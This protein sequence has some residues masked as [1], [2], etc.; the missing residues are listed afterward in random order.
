M[1]FAYSIVSEPLDSF[2]QWTSQ[3]K[4]ILFLWICIVAIHQ[5]TIAQSEIDSLK[6]ILKSNYADSSKVD[7]YLLLNTKMQDD[8]T[9][10]QQYLREAIALATKIKD[11]IRLIKCYRRLTN[12]YDQ[13]G[14]FRNA[15]I[16]L[17]KMREHLPYSKNEKPR[18]AYYMFLGIMDYREGAYDKALE[19][20]W[21]ALRLFENL[22]DSVTVASCYLNI[23][24]CYKELEDYT[25]T[26]KY[27]LQGLK[28]YESS[29]NEAL[30]AMAY[31][32]IGNVHK[33]RN[34]YDSALYYYNKSLAVNRRLNLKEDIHID[35]NNIGDIFL[36]YKDYTKAISYFKESFEVSKSI[37]FEWGIASSML[38]LGAAKMEQ[39]QFAE[40]LMILNEA[41]QKAKTKKY[42][43]LLRKA[44]ELISLTHERMGNFSK[45]LTYRKQFESL[46]DSLLNE[47]YLK[48]AKE[49]ELKYET[50]KKDNQIALLAK[51]N[52]L[53]EREAQRQATL[54]NAFIIGA[55]FMLFI[56]GLV[57]YIFKQRLKNQ[58]IIANKN[59][60]LKEIS[61]TKQATELEMK[62]LRAQINPH[63]LFNCMNSI[64]QMIV[65]GENDKASSYLTKFSKL[66]RLI[67]E[68]A[69]ATKVVL[70]DE[71]AL[72][73]AYIQMESLRFAGK[74]QYQIDVAPGIDRSATYIPPMVLQ[75]FVE[76]AIWH[77][78]MHK[79]KPEE[80]SIRLMISEKDDVLMCSIE[81]NGV[82]VE[83]SK[84]LQEKS[85]LKTKSM[86]MSITEERLKLL[87]GGRLNEF[88]KVMDRCD[89]LNRVLGTQVQVSIPL[90]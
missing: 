45:A 18:A 84:Q 36:E 80:G 66:V 44:Y 2:M 52:E 51:E 7:T 89:S 37:G 38:S 19:N 77:G 1:N 17:E 53:S 75:P 12:F 20:L 26:L 90:F 28:I 42:K 70:E 13:N 62:A 33:N 35:L 68:N 57:F 79:E 88:V 47:S 71:L 16:A 72:L 85:L 10:A 50:E 69:H 30:T 55:V 56:A 15:R 5:R 54:K 27:Y 8:T 9:A 41:S 59:A 46:K 25:N 86:G 87:A 32:N 65:R 61:F 76:N 81:D 83:R 82:G 21:S 31:G 64:N 4:R 48:I 78:L 11:H 3:I 63:F 40:A 14:D 60:Q 6:N 22:G 29:G 43:E 24:N 34:D 39:R 58:S 74:I 23:G 49:Q 67:V 73:E